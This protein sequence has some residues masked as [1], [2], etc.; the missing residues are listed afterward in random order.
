M[1]MLL[2]SIFN[3]SKQKLIPQLGAQSLWTTLASE[4]DVWIHFFK[5]LT[6]YQG[7]TR[8]NN[9]VA[10]L[11]DSVFHPKQLTEDRMLYFWLSGQ[12]F[13]LPPSLDILYSYDFGLFA[14]GV[15]L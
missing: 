7:L 3:R 6:I 8:Y 14:V 11:S 9:S 15:H 10:V 2:V 5:F 4:A 13:S 1:K 12:S